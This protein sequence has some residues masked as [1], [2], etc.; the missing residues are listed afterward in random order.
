[1]RRL[2]ESPRPGPRGG[3]PGGQ[4]GAGGPG[5]GGAGGHSVG[6]AIKG[7]TLPNL[8][9][10]KITPGSAGMGGGGGDMDMTAQ[11]KGDSGMTCKTLDFGSTTSPCAM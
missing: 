3:G 9:S 5:G 1:M 11:T 8:G 4:G 7:G 6:V 10:T 2:D